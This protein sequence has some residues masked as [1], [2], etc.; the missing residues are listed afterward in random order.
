VNDNVHE[1]KVVSTSDSRVIKAC[2]TCKYERRDGDDRSEF[3][4]EAAGA[5]IDES[6]DNKSWCGSNFDWW[7]PRPEP[8]PPTPPTPPVP[9]LAR[10]KRWLVG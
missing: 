1:L 5:P 10:F 2:H 9:A 6:L 8:P 3:W 4:C 7:E